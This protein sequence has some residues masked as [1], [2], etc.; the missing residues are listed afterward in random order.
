MRRATFGTL[1][2]SRYKGWHF[3]AASRIDN[4]QTHANTQIF[5]ME[6]ASMSGDDVEDL[7]TYSFSVDCPNL[8]AR[9][10]GQ[11]QKE[12]YTGCGTLSQSAKGELT[13]KAFVTP[14]PGHSPI[15]ALKAAFGQS[16]KSKAGEIIPDDE[17]F[18]LSAQS[19]NGQVWVCDRFLPN[20]TRSFATDGTILCG[21]LWRMTNKLS[22]PGAIRGEQITIRY[23]NKPSFPCNTRTE[24]ETTIGEQ[25]GWSGSWNVA[26]FTAAG[27]NFSITTEDS[28]MIVSAWID[29]G[30]LPAHL[31]TR[32]SEA[33]S[34]L[35]GAEFA[36]FAITCKRTDQTT[37]HYFSE[38]PR[39][40]KGDYP[41]LNCGLHDPTKSLWHLFDRYLSHICSP[42]ITER[43]HPL[44][45]HLISVLRAEEASVDGFALTLAVAVEGILNCAFPDKAQPTPESI[46]QADAALALISSSALEENFKRRMADLIG[47]A[48]S[49]R[50]IDKLYALA[51]QGAVRKDFIGS[52]KKL[53]NASA[54]ANLSD[55]KRLAKR[56]QQCQ[57]VRTLL[58][59][60]IFEAIGYEGAFTDY[61]VPGWPAAARERVGTPPLE[62][63]E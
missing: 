38:E 15:D 26:N 13:F 18:Q 10:L 20:F 29:D 30:E 34:F 14:P 21:S 39:P 2:L 59:E 51:A 53:R 37:R 55:Q 33:L 28:G 62:R 3:R 5:F 41:P 45:S 23:R 7:A 27:F 12:A 22:T 19:L 48:K 54:H 9:P 46:A 52:W 31:E 44:S 17:Y 24:T 25:K 35:F 4:F 1:A 63:A 56:H 8:T 58:H 47:S 32:I 43:W 40:L 61:S 49:A 57:I 16:C 60:L 36:P 50:P 6:G 11:D 42:G